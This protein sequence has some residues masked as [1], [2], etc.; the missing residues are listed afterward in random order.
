MRFLLRQLGF[1][2]TRGWVVLLLAIG[3]LIATAFWVG[4]FRP[5]PPDLRLLA[6][7]GDGRFRETITIPSSWADTAPPQPDVPARFPLVLAVYN[8]GA[9]AAVPI[10]LALSIPSQFRIANTN[11][12][13]YEGRATA[14]NP[15]VRYVFEIKPG[16]VTPRQLPRVLS[17]LDTLWLE[18]IMPTYYC[19]ALDSVP[20]FV[21]A[22][23]QDPATLAQL[24]IFYS[25]DARIRARQT[26]LLNLQVDPALLARTPPPTPPSF[27]ARRIDPEYPKPE[28]G[29]LRYLGARVTKCGDPGSTLEIYDALWET[30]EGG[31]FF[32]VYNGGTPRKY[33]FDLNRDSIIELEMWDADGDGRF[34]AGRQAGMVIPEFLMPPRPIV[35]AIDSGALADSLRVDS[36]RV[37]S[38]VSAVPIPA[39]DFQFPPALFHDTDAGPLRFWRALQRARGPALPT[40]DAA[41]PQPTRPTPRPEPPPVRT[42]TS[43]RLLGRPIPGAAPARRDTLRRDTLRAD[44]L[45]RERL[46]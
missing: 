29:A 45:R 13:A 6:L 9:R 28:L 25:F 27:P 36:A 16:R 7:G 8:G 15:L 30:P 20:E 22:P 39:L 11:G 33:L 40:T 37:D 44:T 1:R 46:H 31:R 4:P 12:Q 17:T 34:E 32:V 2:L 10:R 38:P 21:P 23:Q 5:L 41:Q 24:R 42:D 43:P 35:V 19:T 3:A 26:G 18:P 14:G